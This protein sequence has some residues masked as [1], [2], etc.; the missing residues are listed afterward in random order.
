MGFANIPREPP[1][2]EDS[3]KALTFVSILVLCTGI[4]T[5]QEISLPPPSG[6]RIIGTTHLVFVD[7]T[8]P[9]LFTDD[10]ADH[11]EVTVRIWYPGDADKKART[12]PYYDNA[13]Q[14]VPRFGYPS[15]LLDLNTN[16][17]LEIPVLRQ[18]DGYPVILF[19]HGWGEHAAQNTVLMEELASHGYVVVSLAHHY[20][21]KYWAYPDGNLGFLD[22]E[23]PRLKKIFGEQSKP[24]VMDL[25]QTMFTTK[26]AA[27]QESLF[28]QTVEVMPTFLGE[29]PRIWAEDIRFVIDQLDSLNRSEEQF[30]GN[31]DLGRLGVM[32]MSMGGIAAGQACIIEP[33][34]K[35]GINI[36]G[37]LLGDLADTM[38]TQPMFYVGSRRFIDYD[39]V[40][41][42]HA[43]GDVYTLTIA[44]ADHY[45]FTDFTL[46]HREHPMIGTV[47]GR[48]MLD[49]MNAYTLAFF[50][51]YLRGKES[52]LI[53]GKTRPYD[54]VDFRV[55]KIG[56]H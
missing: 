16:S 13:E 47:D 2:E 19:N 29:S 44:D 46:L 40:F 42:D 22:V 53:R 39:E 6:D 4:G 14:I 8:R 23:S 33:R 43:A 27:A 3:M 5:A 31:L 21:A 15:T 41:A 20:E 49:I 38:V 17:K 56:P 11:R 36:D 10:P 18:E 55:H 7:E 37:G 26:G 35:A 34:I 50:D 45:D 54:E 32:G 1:D 48:R 9:E 12:A 30:E 25:F 52:D 51:L 24:G 28:R